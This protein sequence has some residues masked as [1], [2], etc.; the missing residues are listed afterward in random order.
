MTMARKGS[1]RI[2]VD[3]KAYRWRVNADDLGWD[4]VSVAVA[5]DEGP[6]QTMSFQTKGEPLNPD[7]MLGRHG[8]PHPVVNPARVAEAIRKAT[9]R[10]WQADQ[11]GK[12]F[13]MWQLD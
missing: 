2:S 9:S 3:G 12:P 8:T 7:E 1:R 13:P 11:P 5:P 4:Y 6:R 10:G